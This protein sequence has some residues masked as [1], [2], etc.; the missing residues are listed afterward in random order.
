MF[1]IHSLLL[2]TYD[3][4]NFLG[5]GGNLDTGILIFTIPRLDIKEILY[6]YANLK[7]RILLIVHSS[8]FVQ[9][10]IHIIV[11]TTYVLYIVI[12]LLCI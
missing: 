1:Y 7:G 11:Y 2:K 5:G 6:D 12:I 4:L 8:Y 9:Y 10:C 3:E